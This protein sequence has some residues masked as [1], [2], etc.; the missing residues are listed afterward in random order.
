MY[1]KFTAE[2]LSALITTAALIISAGCIYIV[3][4]ERLTGKMTF[5]CGYKLVYIESGSME[6][7]IKTGSVIV[8]RQ[9]EYSDIKSGDIITF[10]TPEGYVTHRFV[11]EDTEAEKQGKAYLITKGDANRIEDIERIEPAAVKG[12]A[13]KILERKKIK[14]QE[15]KEEKKRT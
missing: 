1:L 8:I 11:G 15:K 12:R 6:P 3:A 9:A 10:E 5:L 14:W 13:V 4:H 2:S 7:A